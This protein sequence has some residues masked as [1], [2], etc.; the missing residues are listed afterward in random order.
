MWFFQKR[1]HNLRIKDLI[2]LSFLKWWRQIWLFSAYFLCDEWKHYS[3]YAIGVRYFFGECGSLFEVDV[4]DLLL[5]QALD[6]LVLLE[7]DW[8]FKYDFTHEFDV[9][10]SVKVWGAHTHFF[11]IFHLDIL[12]EEHFELLLEVICLQVIDHIN[13]ITPFLILAEVK[14]SCLYRHFIV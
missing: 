9:S 11:G 4:L 10:I 5:K 14:I 2:F 12:F 6:K 7:S 1:I 8:L 3:I 13:L